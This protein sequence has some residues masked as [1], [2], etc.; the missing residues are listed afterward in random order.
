M[1]GISQDSTMSVM[2]FPKAMKKQRD[3]NNMAYYVHSYMESKTM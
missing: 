3:P 1:L 2:A